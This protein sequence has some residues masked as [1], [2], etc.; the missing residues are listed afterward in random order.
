M[1][2]PEIEIKR[3][4][5]FSQTCLCVDEVDNPIDLSSWSFE[6]DLKLV[7]SNEKLVTFSI[8]DTAA[9]VGQIR[10]SA[11]PADT[12]NLPPQMSMVFDIKFTDPSGDI[13]YSENIVLTTS[14]HITH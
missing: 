1:P 9:A 7:S 2:A 13:H 10:V 14:K 11:P 4:S 3:G 5:T 6:S 12:L 8:D